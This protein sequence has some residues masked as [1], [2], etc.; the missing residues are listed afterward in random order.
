MRRGETIWYERAAW[1]IAILVVFG[2]ASNFSSTSPVAGPASHQYAENVPGAMNANHGFTEQNMVASWPIAAYYHTKPENVEKAE[3]GKGFVDSKWFFKLRMRTRQQLFKGDHDS[4]A[5]FVTKKFKAT[6]MAILTLGMWSTHHCLGSAQRI[7]E[8]APRMDKVLKYARSKGVPIIWGGST[9]EVND[10]KYWESTPMRKNMK[11]LP[12]VSLKDHGLF[13]PPLPID[14][15][16]GGC[17][18][19]LNPN[20]K[21]SEVGFHAGIEMDKEKDVLSSKAKEILNFLHHRGIKVLVMMGAHTNMC[22]LDRPYAM[23]Q[24]VR[25]GFPVVLVRDLTDAMYNPQKWPYVSQNEG[26]ELTVQWIESYM[27][28]SIHSDDLLAAFEG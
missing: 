9:W 24:Y 5:M 22:I 11:G 8:M 28:P 21:R 12:F 4:E 14:D 18:T 6:E 26:T 15:S 20:Y 7:D 1:C 23:K 3:T 10:K 2:L 17:D 27:A 13:A 16:D 19:E 25:Y